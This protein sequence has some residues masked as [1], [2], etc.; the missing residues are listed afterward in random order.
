MFR[1]KRASV[2]DF[3]E[4]VIYIAI[5]SLI[6]FLFLSYYKIRGTRI[7][8]DA[9]ELGAKAYAGNILIQYL[10]QDISPCIQF[11]YPM[12]TALL[13]G[14][15]AFSYSDLISLLCIE[16]LQEEQYGLRK[17]MWDS[18]TSYFFENRSLERYR[19][20]V[21]SR[22][23]ELMSQAFGSIS[24]STVIGQADMPSIVDKEKAIRVYLYEIMP[25]ES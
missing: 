2:D 25:T 13:T 17:D 16:F 22:D 7:I 5:I 19:I 14:K 4:L 11:K 18:C 9:S 8:D 3:L 10:D 12:Q 24:K 23:E 21:Y 6:V 1:N 15:G 20:K